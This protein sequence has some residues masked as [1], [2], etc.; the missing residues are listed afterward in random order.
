M[1]ENTT[2]FEYVSITR[3]IAVLKQELEN[4]LRYKQNYDIMMLHKELD[5]T[6]EALLDDSEALVIEI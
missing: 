3:K 1:K 2:T 5:R 6:L 4:F